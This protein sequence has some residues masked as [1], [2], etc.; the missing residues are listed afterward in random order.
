MD[1][2]ITGGA[3]FIGSHL[4]EAMH[5]RGDRVTIVDDL[6]TGSLDNIRHLIDRPGFR[7]VRDSVRNETIMTALIDRCDVVVHLA[8]AV[9]VRLIA[10]R[11]VHTIETNIHG[12][13]VVLSLAGK[14][15]RKI[16]VASTSE[17]YGKSAQVPFR[18]D[19]DA[20][21]GS[22]YYSRWC[23]GCSKM[24]DEFLALAY[25]QQFALPAVICRFFNIIGPRQTGQYGM[26]VPR[27]VQ[28][29]LA[30]QTLEVCGDGAQVRC[31][32]NVS[33]LVGI[34]L[35]LIECDQAVGEVINVGSDEA[36]SIAD[37]ARRV[38][39]LTGSTSD[40]RLV[41]YEEFYGRPIDD[42][43][44]RIPDLTK[45]NRLLSYE[46]LYSLDD[47]LKEVIDHHRRTS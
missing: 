9:G 6:S 25:H 32:C 10:E 46:R 22:T 44:V 4:A 36:I 7:F 30:G 24:I 37:L 11:P 42:T 3:G 12:S 21:L 19:Q 23:Y 35:E 2:L 15:Q 34:L 38:I 39:D 26:V 43:P 47:T 1:V 8:A 31:F 29:A 45:L 20:V 33:D 13:E 28:R 41:S 16:L 18:E 40:L 27:F 14:Y 5:G 17:V